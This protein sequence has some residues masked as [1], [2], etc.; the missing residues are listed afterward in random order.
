[1]LFK[2]DLH[3]VSLY[4]LMSGSPSKCKR[5]TIS[6]IS[7]LHCTL[8]L[9]SKMLVSLSSLDNT[10]YNPV[11]SSCLSLRYFISRANQYSAELITSFG[12]IISDRNYSKIDITSHGLR[13]VYSMILHCS[14]YRRCYLIRISSLLRHMI[15]SRY[16][17]HRS[18]SY[19]YQLHGSSVLNVLGT[20]GSIDVSLKYSIMLSH[21]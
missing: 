8:L 18:F 2:V 21:H 12:G 19:L 6:R 20:C 13:I 17:E 3:H 10:Q 4:L 14:I 5:N 9:T 1:M 16:K 15:V 11:T 7:L